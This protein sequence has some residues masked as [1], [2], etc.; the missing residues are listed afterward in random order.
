VRAGQPGEPRFTFLDTS[1]LVRIGLVRLQIRRSE[2]IVET[3]A[4]RF[5]SDADL[6]MVVAV[7]YGAGRLDQGGEGNTRSKQKMKDR[8]SI[9]I[10]KTL[11]AT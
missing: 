7:H 8:C 11:A 6:C 3:G 9:P 2:R 4:Y 5:A 10:L 1:T